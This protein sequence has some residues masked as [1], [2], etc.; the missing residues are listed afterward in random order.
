[1]AAFVAGLV[2][3]VQ[4]EEQA[5]SRLDAMGI[6]SP[7][8]S[9]NVLV[10]L[11]RQLATSYDAG[12]PILRT[13]EMV[14]KNTR[15]RAAREVIEGMG[16]AIRK[17]ATLGQAARAQKDRL[18][19]LMVELLES[20]EVGGNLDVA[21]RDMA[22]YFEERQRMKRTIIGKA[23]YPAL[24]LTAAWFLGSFALMLIRRMNFTDTSFNLNDY[25]Q[26]YM[27]FQGA[28]ML[29]FGSGVATSIVLARLGL[30]KW[31]WGYVATHV[32]PIAP[33]TRRFAMAR[34]FRSLSLLIGSGVPIVRALER[35]AATC[36]NPYIER[37][38]L[39]PVPLVA[40]GATLVEAFERSQYLP[41]TAREM[42]LVGEQSGKLE[43]ALNKA[44]QYQMDEA[45]HAVNVATRVGEV[46]ISL[47][48][49]AVVGYI[50]ISF[51]SNY[52]GKLDDI[53]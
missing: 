3:C 7:Q 43:A 31:I 5:G 22:N 48:V 16:R 17:G 49:A 23:V 53:K 15:D 50:V 35:A 47:A 19:P 40:N 37:D 11:C 10:P 8:L 4:E 52:L 28:A 24:Q 14:H 27:R 20:G 32:W 21:L 44:A 29:L 51:Y 42:L 12:I 18:P 34:Y 1:L 9:T 33:V 46:L 2:E 13:L 6:V 25:F 39:K 38:L 45:V 30:F 26:Y 36:A 41:Q